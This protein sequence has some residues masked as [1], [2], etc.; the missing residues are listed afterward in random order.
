MVHGRSYSH[1]ERV[2]LRRRTHPGNRDAGPDLPGRVEE[3]DVSVPVGPA[4]LLGNLTLP[5]SALGVVVFAHGSGSGRFSPRNRHVA[6]LLNQEGLGTLLLDLL[7]EGE[8]AIDLRTAEYRFNIELLS[9]RLMTA[10]EFCQ[11][12]P[13]TEGL[14]MGYFG[15]STGAAAAIIAAV[16]GRAKPAALVSRGG[17][18]DLAGRALDA[19]R[20]PTL[21]IVGSLDETVLELNRRAL[22]AIPG[23]KKLEVV[24]GAT[25]LFEEP[26]KLDEVARLSAEWFRRYM[27]GRA[28]SEA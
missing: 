15:A 19:L 11:E 12:N 14:P 13:A 8:E 26:G 10:G 2:A 5:D 25:H 27:H 17:R 16:D 9:Q 3:L 4:R 6:R 7:T 28:G 21:L 24:P 20:T 22:A 1:F 23:E 18:P